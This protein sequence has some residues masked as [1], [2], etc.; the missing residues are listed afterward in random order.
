MS[1]LSHPFLIDLCERFLSAFAEIDPGARAETM[2]QDFIGG[3][4]RVLVRAFWGDVFEK[5]CVSEITATVVIPGRDYESSIQWLGIQT[6]PTNPLVPMFMGVFEHV[7]EQGLRHC[8]CYFDV[9]PVEP[10]DEDRLLLEKELGAV[11]KKHG[12]VYPDLPAGYLKMFRLKEPGIGVG[13]AVGVAL[14]PEEENQELFEEL[15]L[16]ACRAYCELVNHRKENVYTAQ[17]KDAMHRFR[18]RWVDFIYR[19][20]R[21]FS[22]GIALG[23]PVE[24]FMLHML[25]PTVRF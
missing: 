21:F 20:N 17:Q 19:E 6:F 22:G 1:L 18:S 2:Q 7:Q 4:G 9:F 15:A 11:C 10:F 24:C 12:R 14:E 5:A 13:Y 25:P 3:K 8:P 16:A 23:V